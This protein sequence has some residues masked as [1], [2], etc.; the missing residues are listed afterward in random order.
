MCSKYT[1]RL[2]IDYSTVACVLG[3]VL[4]NIVSIVA[5]TRIGC[6]IKWINMR[7]DRFNDERVAQR[8]RS[9]DG[10]NIC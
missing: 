3:V 7:L 5:Q 4:V 9:A 10:V 8:L 2:E 1:R 6:I